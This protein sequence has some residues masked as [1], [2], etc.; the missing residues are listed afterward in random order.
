MESNE[1]KAKAAAPAQA[2][3]VSADRRAFMKTVVGGT[4]AAALVASAGKAEAATAAMDPCG[5]PVQV[6]RASVRAKIVLNANKFIDRQH[7]IDVIGDIFDGSNCPN[8]GL[9]GI[10]DDPRHIKDIA[11]ARAHL[12]DGVASMVVFEEP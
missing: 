3:G 4:A 2:E 10:P 7:I 5:T 11:V 8:C 6:P 9:I 12:P 1:S